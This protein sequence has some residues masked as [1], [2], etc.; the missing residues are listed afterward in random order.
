MPPA[1]QTPRLLRRSCGEA[2]RLTHTPTHVSVA[3]YTQNHNTER[4]FHEISTPQTGRGWPRLRS[5]GDP[6]A[7]PQERFAQERHLA[8]QLS[9]V[10]HLALNLGAG[11]N[12]R[13]VV[14]A[15]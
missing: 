8:A 2:L 14:A 10:A 12:D 15:A 5:R 9:V 4:V 7:K 1:R 13:R 3:P 11:V 6:L